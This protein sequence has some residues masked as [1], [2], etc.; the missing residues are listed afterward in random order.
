MARL[1]QLP[2]PSLGLRSFGAQAMPLLTDDAL[3]SAAG[4]RVA[5]SGRAGGVSEGAYGTL[6]LGLHVGDDA[7]CVREN[8]RRLMAALGAPD[9]PLVVPSQVHGADLVEVDDRRPLTAEVERAQA[10]AR[11]G[12][13]GVIVA[14]A[15]VAALLCFADCVPVVIVSPGGRFA[16]VHAGWRGVMAHIAPV[17]AARLAVADGVDAAR[18]NVYLGPHIH[19]ECFETGAD[20]R[21]AFAEHFGCGCAPDA[22][23]VDLAR[24]LAED[25]SRAGVRRERI[26]DADVCTKCRADGY[27]SYRASGGTCGRHGA[28]A[29][30]LE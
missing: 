6:N 1:G 29:F 30:R 7:A 28:V 2:E 21:D 9:V 18:L 27:F 20:V 11:E 16:V 3:F 19:A 4:V 8:R 17:A 25:L 24:A 23:H 26:A 5:F 12:A 14:A 22:R 15:R 10:R 13:D